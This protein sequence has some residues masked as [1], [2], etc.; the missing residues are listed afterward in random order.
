MSFVHEA[1]GVEPAVVSPGADVH[2]GPNQAAAR[3]RDTSRERG[4]AV[5]RYFRRNRSL[6]TRGSL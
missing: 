5:F 1:T 3:P 2:L 4:I 6:V